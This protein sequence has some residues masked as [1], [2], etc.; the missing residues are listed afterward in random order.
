VGGR[1]GAQ[2]RADR[3]PGTVLGMR[4]PALPGM[5]EIEAMVADVWS[6]GLSPD[7]HPVQFVRSYLNTIGAVPIGKLPTLDDGRRILVGGVVTHRQR[8]ATASGITFLNLEDETGMLNVVCS[9]GLWQ[10]FRRVARTANAMLIRGRLEVVDT[11]TNL[12]AEHLAPL[13]LPVT[14]RSRDFR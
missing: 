5:D 10:R 9:P 13:Q 6:M 14:A 8:P 3:L 2:E 12:V 7:S 4:A 1:G 11:V